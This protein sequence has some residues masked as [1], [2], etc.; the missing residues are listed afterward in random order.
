MTFLSS[1]LNKHHVVLKKGQ[2]LHII[3]TLLWNQVLVLKLQLYKWLHGIHHPIVHYY[4]VCWNE[5]KMLPFMFDHYEQFV[6]RFTIFDNF[7]TD[8][9]EA[10]INSHR[11]T[12]I[13][14]FNT[15]G[16]LNDIIQLN[17]KN[18]CWKQSRG[19]ADYVIVCDIDEFFYHPEIKTCLTQIRQHGWTITRPHGFEMYSEHYP[20]Y[21]SK[22]RITEMVR[23]GVASHWYNKSILF[24][25]HKIVEVNYDPGCHSCHPLGC[26]CFSDDKEIKL[27]HYKNLEVDT[28]I[29][30]Y[31]ECAERLSEVNIKNEFGFHYLWKEEQIK[32]KFYNN[33]KACSQII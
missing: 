7:S 21:D 11:N 30:R 20:Q 10:I 1:L 5:E 19:K 6:D 15:E 14:K 24:D 9:S 12:E 16:K 33:L 29:K 25:P 32:N 18:N 27:L 26:V 3:W 4:A 17:I 28:V 13:K 2:D 31:R 8:N 23:M 22:R